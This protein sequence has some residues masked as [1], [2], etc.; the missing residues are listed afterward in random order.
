MEEIEVD[1]FKFARKQLEVTL[2]FQINGKKIYSTGSVIYLGVRIDENLTLKQKFHQR[3]RNALKTM[4]YVFCRK[5]LKA[6][7][8]AIFDSYLYSSSFAWAKSL[9]SFKIM[10]HFRD[11]NVKIYTVLLR[12]TY[13]LTLTKLCCYENICTDCFFLS[14]YKKIHVT[15]LVVLLFPR[16]N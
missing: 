7:Y 14:E 10:T 16:I 9:K 8:F 5:I 6:I 13:T 2:K 11:K 1:I 15:F 12:K 3:K 4:H